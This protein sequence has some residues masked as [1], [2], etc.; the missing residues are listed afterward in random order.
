MTLR[1]AT[2]AERKAAL[3]TPDETREVRDFQALPTEQKR[4][5]VYQA[6]L[7]LDHLLEAL[8]A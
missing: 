4:T 6:L 5:A 7:K 8:P 3:P 2:I 1:G